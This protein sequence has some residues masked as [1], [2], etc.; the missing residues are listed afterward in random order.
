MRT[1]TARH[2]TTRAVRISRWPSAY[3][4]R[5]GLPTLTAI[6]LLLAGCGGSSTSSSTGA[7]APASAQ[8][9]ASA[10]LVRFAQCMRS[11]GVPS[12]PDPVNGRLVLGQGG[13]TGVNPSSPAF[14]SASQSCKSLAPQGTASPAQSAQSS[15]KAVKFAQCMRAHGVPNFPDPT[16][17]G[18]GNFSMNLP[19][20]VDPNSPQFQAAGQACRSFSVLP[21]GGGTP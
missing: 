12:F 20:G 6:A 4:G 1:R 17:V 19:P 3:C 16:S 7:G 11:H 5:V 13:S 14:Q 18:G 2:G 15:A 8:S 21:G 10:R 9:P